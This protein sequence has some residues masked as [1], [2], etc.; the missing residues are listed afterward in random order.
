[1]GEAVEKK[2]RMNWSLDEH[3]K[4]SVVLG[5]ETFSWDCSKVHADLHTKMMYHGFKQ[6]MVD[7]LAGLGNGATDADKVKELNE[8]FEALVAGKW[9][10]R[11]GQA[12][13]ALVSMFKLIQ[14]IIDKDA[15]IT[16][17][18]DMLVMLG[19]FK[20]VDFQKAL[21]VLVGQGMLKADHDAVLKFIGQE[22]KEEKKEEP[23]K[24]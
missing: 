22:V 14:K 16:A 11:T 6:L 18:K 17:Q 19:I 8:K 15:E 12:N 10:Q 4:L 5:K 23:K 1:M 13:E 21:K 20:T 7:T 3:G 24:K 9:S 2:V